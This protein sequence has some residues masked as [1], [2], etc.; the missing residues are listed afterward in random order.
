MR[1]LIAA[2]GRLRTGAERD[3]VDDYL[4]RLA[5][6]GRSVAIGPA[7]L[8][9]IPEGRTATAHLRQAGEANGLIKAAGGG[10]IVT[11]DGRGQALTSAAFARWLGEQRDNGAR[12]VAFLIGGPDGHG[13]E[14]V[15]AATLKLSLGAM[16]FPHGLARVLLAEQLYRAATILAGHPYHRE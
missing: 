10:A 4:A 7:S 13:S 3:L 12:T 11:L 6:A 14:A 16:T 2:V 1:L 8:V 5:H 9:E 15:K